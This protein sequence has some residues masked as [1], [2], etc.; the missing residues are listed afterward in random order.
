METANID[1]KEETAYIKVYNIQHNSRYDKTY[2]KH[3]K[4][5]INDRKIA[6]SH[7]AVHKPPKQL[8]KDYEKAKSEYTENLNR[9]ALE[10]LTNPQKKTGYRNISNFD[11]EKQIG[12]EIIKNKDKFLRE[13]NKRK[14]IDS[15]IIQNEFQISQFKAKKIQKYV[16]NTLSGT[17]T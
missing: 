13:Y 15:N 11:E 7:I 4:F 14:F 3:P 1:Y 6:M 17:H 16:E 2:F 5:K 8:T 9:E 12:Q 10:S